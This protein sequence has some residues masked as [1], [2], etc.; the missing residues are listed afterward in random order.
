M[1]IRHF[2]DANRIQIITRPFKKEKNIFFRIIYEQYNSNL[3]DIILKCII[4]ILN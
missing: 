1:L 3:Y 2:R 4:L